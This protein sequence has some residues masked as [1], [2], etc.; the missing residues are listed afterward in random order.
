MKVLI[1]GGAGYVGSH[2]AKELAR[3]GHEVFAYD[4][5]SRGNRWAVKWGPLL[6]GDLLDEETLTKALISHRIEAVLHFAALAYVGE[7]VERPS[8]YFRNNVQGSLALLRAMKAAQVNTLIFSSTCAVFG[9]PIVLP[10][11]EESPKN[12]LSP[13]GES[14]RIIEQI[15]R[16][17]GEC[18]G[19]AGGAPLFTPL[20]AIR[21]AKSGSAIHR[22]LT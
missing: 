16:W 7:S 15:L 13:Y 21:R 22:K 3:A 2:T 10:V 11:S 18:D 6:E 17:S 1:T 19:F 9:N 20:Q 5:L 8:D 12:P 14:K 4:N